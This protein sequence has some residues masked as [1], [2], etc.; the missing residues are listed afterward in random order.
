MKHFD[1]VD[2]YLSAL[3][4][5]VRDIVKKLRET[6]RQAAPQAEEAIS[7]N[8]PAFKQDGIL[9]WY[10]AFKK[11]IGFFPKT[12]AIAAFRDDL[13]AYKTSKGTIQFPIEKGIPT[14]LVKR[15]VKFRVNENKE[16][17]AKKK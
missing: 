17:K 14:N 9:V 2:E 4:K 6:I 8:M 12:S 1:T 3:P 11:H 13:A 7:Y 15:I 5:D 16:Q 10:A